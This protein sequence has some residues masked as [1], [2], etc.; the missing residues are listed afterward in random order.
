M[1]SDTH[2]YLCEQNEVCCKQGMLT[3]EGGRTVYTLG[4]GTYIHLHA[5]T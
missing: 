3:K 1:Q 4:L 2:M 5:Q